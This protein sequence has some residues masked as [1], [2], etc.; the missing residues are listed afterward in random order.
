MI[1]KILDKLAAVP[2]NAYVLGLLG[3]FAVTSISAYFLNENTRLLERKILSRQ[4]DYAEV[5]QLKD[6][7][8]SKKHALEKAPRKAEIHAITLGLVEEMVAK[9]FVGGTLTALQPVTNKEDK[10]AQHMA[11]E[12]KVAGAALGEIVSFVRAADNSGLRVGKLRLSQ[13]AANPTVLDVQATLME[14][15]SNG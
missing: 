15:R 8:E 13:Q 10:T 9:N 12:V 7:Y 11:V 2:L 1:K 4:K 14:K 3:V 6:L 5:L